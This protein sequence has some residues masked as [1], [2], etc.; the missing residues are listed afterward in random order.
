MAQ[1]IPLIKAKIKEMCLLRGYYP[2]SHYYVKELNNGFWG[3]LLITYAADSQGKEVYVNLGIYNN[4]IDQIHK[5][6][7]GNGKTKDLRLLAMPN[8]GWLFGDNPNHVSWHVRDLSDIDEV[9]DSIFN[10]IDEIAPAFFERLP[11][12][13]YIIAP[14]VPQMCI[15][16][17]QRLPQRKNCFSQWVMSTCMLGSMRWGIAAVFGIIVTM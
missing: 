13:R 11:E 9:C 1:I 8:I 10:I 5:A 12:A 16:T 17:E 3:L 7:H 4:E 2:K 15:Y 6:I 14:H